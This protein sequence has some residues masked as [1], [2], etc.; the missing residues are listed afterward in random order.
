MD[1]PLHRSSRACQSGRSGKGSVKHVL[2]HQD[3]FAKFY[4]IHVPG[5]FTLK[6]YI[7]VSMDQVDRY[8]LPKL[9]LNYLAT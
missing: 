6:G 4:V 9:I 2:S 3:I 8:P 1:R 5:A 7:K